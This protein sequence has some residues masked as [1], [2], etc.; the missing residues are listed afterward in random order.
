MREIA[1]YILIALSAPAVLRRPFLGVVIYLGANIVRPEMLF[2]GG[3]GGS[4]VFITYYLLILTGCLLRGELARL[5]QVF[6]REY[7]L[8]LWMLAAIYLSIM[9]TQFQAPMATYFATDIAKTLGLCGLLYL[10]IKKLADVELLE[11]TLL[12]C[13]TFLGI[14][15]IEQ[16]MLGN[17]RLE[18]LGGAAWGDSNGVASVYVLF[19]PVALAFA[20]ASRKR[21]RFWIFMGVAAVMVALIVCT[22]SRGGLL[23]MTACLFSFA[24]YARK[25]AATFKVAL[26]LA[27]LVTP[28]ATDA[29]LERMKT[30]QGVSDV[31][32]FEGS[33]RSRFI[34]WEAGL[35]VFSRSPVVGTGFLTYPEA[36]MEFEENFYHLEDHFRE[37]VFRKES[38]KVTHNTYIQMLSDCGVFGALPFFLLV[39]GGIRSGFKARGSLK[40]ERDGA[41]GLWLAGCSAGLT[42]FSVCIITIDSITMPFIYVQL[43]VIGI[44]SRTLSGSPAGL[45]PL[46]EPE[47][48][49]AEQP[50]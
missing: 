39:A 45:P 35:M 5:G 10:L 36:K 44:L 4:F 34:L 28:F 15:G 3:E 29:Y 21:R 19:L 24:I 7:L 22:K 2:W 16:Q 8:M 13:L 9:L 48:A 50:A 11:T 17:E 12:G 14:W 49:V 23:G 43:V 31:E 37:W 46:A 47:A 1:L 33:A 20:Y 40:E 42:G 41:A 26:L 6:Q 32:N 18:G 38:K 25:T 30:L 27:L